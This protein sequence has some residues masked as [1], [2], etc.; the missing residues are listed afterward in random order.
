MLNKIKNVKLGAPVFAIIVLILI[1][2]C[3]FVL[4][5]EINDYRNIKSEKH[6]FYYYF[7]N[8]R[9]DFDASI[10]LDIHDT[11]LSLESSG[12]AI[13]NTPIYFKDYNDKVILPANMEI[14]YPYKSIPMYKVGKFSKLYTQNN[15]MYINSEAGIGRLYDCFLYD[16]DNLYVFTENTTVIVDDKRYE[17]SPMS[18]VYVSSSSINIYNM[19]KDEYVNVDSLG[20]AEAYTEEYVIN[21]LD[22]SF[23]YNSRYYMLIKNIEKLDFCEF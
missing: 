8:T 3:S 15:Y 17:L 20:K 7:A 4:F 6:K 2:I 11:I 21:L 5:F 1:L 10:T 12:I 19:K 16:G 23:T 9:V 22:D 14:V 13:D 18:Y